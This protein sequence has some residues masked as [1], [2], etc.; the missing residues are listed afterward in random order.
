MQG[1]KFVLGYNNFGSILVYFLRV[2]NENNFSTKITFQKAWKSSF[3]QNNKVD[4]IDKLAYDRFLKRKSNF[5]LSRL[6]YIY[7]LEKF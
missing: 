6:I 7:I 4:K 5:I 3:Q 1:L 2:A